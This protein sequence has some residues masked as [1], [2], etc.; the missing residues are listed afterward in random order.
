MQHVCHF[1]LDDGKGIEKNDC[2]LRVAKGEDYVAEAMMVN[3]IP[4]TPSAEI[5]KTSR[6][7]S[8]L[9]FSANLKLTT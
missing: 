3:N 6:W 5:S 7:Q 2:A 1:L 9:L 8:R 4:F